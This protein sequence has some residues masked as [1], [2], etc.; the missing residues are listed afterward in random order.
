MLPFA[1]IPSFAR[2][3]L[4]SLDEAWQADVGILGVP[5]DIALGYRPGDFPVSERIAQTT[6]SLPM[7]PH[8]TDAE[9]GAVAD[10]VRGA[11]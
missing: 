9:V 1:G 5:F 7:H 11:L 10:A 2:S 4:E 8:L 3:P 6:L